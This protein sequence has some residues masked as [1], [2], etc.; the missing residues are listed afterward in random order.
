LLLVLA[1]GLGDD[2]LLVNDR[3][4]MAVAAATAQGEPLPSADDNDNGGD[5]GGGG[6]GGGCGGEKV[7]DGCRMR[8]GILCS[9]PGTR[10]ANDSSMFV[11]VRKISRC[12][13]AKSSQ[14]SEPHGRR[15]P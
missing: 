3:N 2:V 5:S 9:S 4:V 10:A 12:A 6:G 14:S 11:L 7:T 13:F 15:C 1:A 8:V